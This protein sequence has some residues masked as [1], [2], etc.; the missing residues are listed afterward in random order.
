MPKKLTKKEKI[1]QDRQY[2]IFELILIL[3]ILFIF[4]GALGID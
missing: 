4:I 1:K 2:N 3:F